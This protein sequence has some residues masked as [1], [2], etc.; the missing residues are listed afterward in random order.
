MAFVLLF[1]LYCVV[2]SEFAF[3][4]IRPLLVRGC[5]FLV[6][7]GCDIANF[8][9]RNLVLWGHWRAISFSGVEYFCVF[10]VLH[11]QQLFGEA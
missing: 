10:E 11:Y 6:E 2:T 7:D 4:D 8:P 1:G 3:V 9:R 5:S